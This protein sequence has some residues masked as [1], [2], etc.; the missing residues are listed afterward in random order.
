MENR[1]AVLDGLDMY[2][3][4][5]YGAVKKRRRKRKSSKRRTTQQNKFAK[6]AKSCSRRRKGSYKS[7]MRKKLKKGRR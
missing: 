3:L 1:I 4:G 6:A 7:C 2:D 5:D